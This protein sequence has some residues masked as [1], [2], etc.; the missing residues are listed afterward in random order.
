MEVALSRASVIQE[1]GSQHQIFSK[2][3]HSYNT[4]FKMIKIICLFV[5][6]A[7]AMAQPMPESKSEKSVAPVSSE[8]QATEGSGDLDKAE[9][10]GFGYHKH[11]YVA[12]RFYGGYYGGYS[13]GYYPH[14]GHHYGGYYPYSPYYGYS[15]Y[16]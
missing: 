3:L 5:V 10:F 16:Y 13:G 4:H 9:T 2:H 14:Y 6:L 1:Q 12:P 11:Y 15:H 7:V 8:M